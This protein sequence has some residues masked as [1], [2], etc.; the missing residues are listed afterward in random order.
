MPL[1]TS[2]VCFINC[3]FDSNHSGMAGGA[4]WVRLSKVR[5]QDCCFINNTSA[6]TAPNIQNDQGEITLAGSIKIDGMPQIV[7]GPKGSVT[8]AEAFEVPLG[9]EF[10]IE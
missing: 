9:S 3:I 2:E 8:L 7:N 1:D 4:L 5:I 6:G 10:L